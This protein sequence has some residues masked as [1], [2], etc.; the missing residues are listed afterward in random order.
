[1]LLQINVFKNL[2]ATKKME[3]AEHTLSTL[4]VINKI[5]EIHAKMLIKIIFNFINYNFKNQIEN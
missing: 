4:F 5:I 3:C 1:L 2:F